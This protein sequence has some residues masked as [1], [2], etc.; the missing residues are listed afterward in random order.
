MG[1]LSQ[2]AISL[3][4]ATKGYKLIDASGYTNKDSVI[5]VECPE[6]HQFKTTLAEFRLASFTC[7]ICDQSIKFVNPTTVPAKKGYRVIACDQATE[8]FGLSIF[9]D[10]KLVFFNLYTFRGH[11]TERLLAI[12]NFVRDIVIKEWQPDFMVFED[13]QYQ[14]GAVLT[15]KIL[16]MLLGIMETTCFEMSIPYE[17]VSPNVWRKYAGTCGK[18][19]LQEKQLSVAA[20]KEKYNVRV[21]DDVAEAILIGR[22]GAQVHKQEI[23]LAFGRKTSG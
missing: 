13:I 21:N 9:D 4:I 20:V 2:E 5:T 18:T 8:R 22:Y 7:P 12:R 19:R 6:G 17:V 15:F 16:A 11:M 14:Y 23:E 1:R 3:E 10:G